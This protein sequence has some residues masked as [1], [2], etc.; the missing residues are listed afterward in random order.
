MR[1]LATAALIAALPFAGSAQETAPSPARNGAVFGDWTLRC[2]AEGV[3]ET[4]CALVQR[5]A[6]AETNAFVAEVGLSRVATAEGDRTLIAVVTPEGT[7]LNLRPAYLI[8]EAVEQVALTWR[9]CANG[10]CR[11][12]AVLTDGQEAA[13]KAGERM[14]L[15]YQFFGQAAPLRL[16]LSLSGV[17]AGLTALGGD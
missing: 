6:Q 11:A 7:A 10:R 5:L 8:D 2:V 15:A 3:G 12:A 13:L 4:T 1:I 17:T 14:T 16:P 9:T